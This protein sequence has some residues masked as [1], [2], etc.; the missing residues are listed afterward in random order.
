MTS[1]ILWATAIGAAIGVIAGT[2]IQYFL[3][4]ALER[5]S[6]KRQ[7]NSL[8]KELVYN[9]SL[10]DELTEELQKMR[11][12]ANGRVFSTYFGYFQFAKG[13]F[14]QAQASAAS[15]ALYDLFSKCPS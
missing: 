5:R 7:K 3:S 11:N 12:A 10:T 14:I 9:R 2:F 8:L 15:G 1:G 4:L 6:Q 13:L